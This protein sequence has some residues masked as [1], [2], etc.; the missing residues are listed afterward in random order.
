MS[1][2][3]YYTIR[4]S[5]KVSHE[6]EFMCGKCMVY[7]YKLLVEK[8]FDSMESAIEYAKSNLPNVKSFV[9]RQIKEIHSNIIKYDRKVTL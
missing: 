7:D 4:S 3:N 8:V 6:V 2:S 5:K 9:I 1:Y